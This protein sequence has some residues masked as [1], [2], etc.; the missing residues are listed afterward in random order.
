MPKATHFSADGKKLNEVDLPAATFGITPNEH[1]VWEAV[2][3]YLANQRQGTAA[4]KTRSM[5]RGG[6]AKPWRQKGTGRARQGSRRSAQWVGGATVFGPQPRS[7]SYRLPKKVRRLA[8]LSA[9]SQRASEGKVG[10][11]DDVTL[12]EPRTK[13]VA[14]LLKGAGLESTKVCII[15]RG[16]NPALMRSH[17]SGSTGRT[18][19]RSARNLPG[20]TVLQHGSLNVYDLIGADVILMSQGALEGIKEV[21]GA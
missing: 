19:K 13:T 11:V 1:V 3:C 4:T 2:R 16:S 5:V 12:S 15:T 10:V 9:L 8:L 20:V 18:M 7:Y 21:F 14:S 17:P 6:G